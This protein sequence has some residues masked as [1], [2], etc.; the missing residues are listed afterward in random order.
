M[1]KKGTFIPVKPLA[2]TFHA[3][4]SI[5]K[6]SH[7]D[8]L[9]LEEG[10]HSHR[11][12]YHIFLLTEDGS[13]YFEIDFEEYFIPPYSALYIHPDQ[14][15][16]VTRT[17]ETYFYLLRIN[18]EHLHQEYL[19]LLELISPAL[20]L[21]LKDDIYALIQQ[22]F[23]LSIS[24]FERKQEKLYPSLLKGSCNTLAALIISR[25][26]Q[27]TPLADH[28]SRFDNITRAFKILLE[29]H[30]TTHKRPSEYA[31]M[32]NISVPYLN[33]CVRKATGVP[34][35]HHIQQRIVLEAKRLLYHSGQSVKE[36]AGQLGY[37]DY[38][39]FSRLF[40]RAAGM[41]AVSFRHKN[42]V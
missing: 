26:L 27:Q 21:S 29:R 10:H 31:K 36:I 11:H 8:L 4:I 40:T 7:T 14:V 6:I 41:T 24:V 2:E 13:T 37:E 20:P 15:H 18:N 42:L 23:L 28:H 30:F 34:V 9:L 25:Y 1:S 33:E 22:A 3:G 19:H 35:S 16:R 17:D 38:A 39:Y 12:D 5:A 32:L